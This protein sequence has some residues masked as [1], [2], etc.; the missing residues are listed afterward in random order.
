MVNGGGGVFAMGVSAYD[1]G[2]TNS[3]NHNL[4]NMIDNCE[5]NDVVQFR[6]YF[7]KYS[8]LKNKEILRETL[9]EYS[10]RGNFIRIYPAKGSDCYDPYF[11]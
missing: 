2:F 1:N 9:T 4:M 3:V 5:D 6:E 10:R 7:K 11:Q 8:T